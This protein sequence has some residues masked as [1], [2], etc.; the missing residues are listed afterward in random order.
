MRQLD[1]DGFDQFWCVFDVD[2]YGSDIDE[3]VRLA[4]RLRVGLAIS[5]PCFE[6][7]LI[8]HF[9]DCSTW[10]RD[11]DDA[12]TRLRRYLPNYDKT[13]LNFDNY[14]SGVVDAV[15]RARSGNDRRVNPAT[16]MWELVQ[17]FLAD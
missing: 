11:A 1:P 13:K 3:A 15:A 9:V 5:N 7:W 16:T 8:L 17:V 12:Q 4:R 10:L 6:F 2:E 14:A